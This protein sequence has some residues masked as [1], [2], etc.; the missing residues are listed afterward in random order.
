MALP[1]L[2]LKSTVA[3]PV[4]TPLRCTVITAVAVPSRTVNVVGGERDGGLV[5]HDREQRAAC[6]PS[7]APP[8]GF[9][10]DRFTVSLPSAAVSLTIGT[11]N[12]RLVRA[13]LRR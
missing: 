2:V 13:G 10:S 6:V 8:L 5:V 1:S 11:V 4:T 9:D 12:V 3:A 7:V